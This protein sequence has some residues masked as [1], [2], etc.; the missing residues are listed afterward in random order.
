NQPYG[1]A[2]ERLSKAMYPASH[3]YSWT[4][5]GEMEDLD[6]AKLQYVQAWYARYYG[7]NNAVLALAGDI[8]VER[9]R[10][11]A[12]KYFGAIPPG[13]PVA[14]PSTWVPTLDS[15]M[16]DTMQDRVPQT[17]IVRAWHLPPVGDADT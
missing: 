13:H 12:Q 9:A 1:R 14:R 10:A 16:R 7:P 17:R 8:T 15:N 3:P 11:L 4:T 6:A 5:I 2:Y